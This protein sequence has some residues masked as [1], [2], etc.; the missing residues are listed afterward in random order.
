MVYVVLWAMDIFFTHAY[1]YVLYED[2]GSVAARLARVLS[3]AR[4]RGTLLAENSFRLGH[5]WAVSSKGFFVDA[6]PAYLSG[7]FDAI[8]PITIPP[9][10]PGEAPGY[11]ARTLVDVRIRPHLLLVAV[12]YFV[13][14]FLFLDLLGIEL[15]WKN[16]YLL[17]LGCLCTLGIADVWAIF[18]AIGSLKKKFESAFVRNTT[19]SQPG[20]PPAAIQ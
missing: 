16:N 19:L 2:A 6:Q 7:S 15:F 20:N 1:Q 10:A 12:A 13:S 3:R 5:P 9:V 17:R 14:I 11:Q 18:R 4:S 8:A